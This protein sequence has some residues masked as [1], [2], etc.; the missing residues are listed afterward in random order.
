MVCPSPLTGKVKRE[1]EKEPTSQ[2]K[3]YNFF[4]KNNLLFSIEDPEHRIYKHYFFYKSN[5]YTLC[6]INK[7]NYNEKCLP[8]RLF[9]RSKSFIHFKTVRHQQCLSQISNRNKLGT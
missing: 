2:R 7:T 5:I 6:H 9:L 1:A 8:L 3:S 4:F